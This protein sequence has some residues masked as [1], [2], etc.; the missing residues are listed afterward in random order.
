MS[1]KIKFKFPDETNVKNV[2][3]TTRAI[4]RSKINAICRETGLTTIQDLLDHP[5]QVIDTI[6]LLVPNDNKFYKANRRVFLSAIMYILFSI[7]YEDRTA[8]YDYYL[9]QK[10]PYVPNAGV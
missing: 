4:Y 2:A 1:S 8:Y 6:E 9:T 5:Q 7:P 10:D 3:K